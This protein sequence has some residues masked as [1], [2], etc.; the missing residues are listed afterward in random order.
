MEQKSSKPFSYETYP[1][2]GVVAYFSMEIAINQGM[3]TYSGGLG[4][5]AGDTLRSAA[6]LGVPLVAFSLVH[7][8]GYFQQ[9]LDL[10]G[11]QS[12]E[13]QQWNPADFCTEEPARVTVSVED[14]IVTVRCWRY[15]LTGRD[16][17]V[18]PIYL[19]DTDVEENSAWDRGLTDH[20]YG[21]DTNYRCSRRSCWAWAACGWPA[22]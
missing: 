18:V 10:K 11:V 13:V 16:G 22:R 5:L 21:G 1:S 20:L 7:R 12:E 19:L 9:H 3:P 4:V 17:H 6:D 8:K 15:D 2:D 14:R